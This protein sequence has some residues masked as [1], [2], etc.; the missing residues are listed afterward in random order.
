[1][2]VIVPTEAVVASIVLTLDGVDVAVAVVAIV[3]VAVLI[4]VPVALALA[5]VDTEPSISIANWISPLTL[6]L[7]EILAEPCN[8]ARLDRL[9][10]LPKASRLSMF[11]QLS[12]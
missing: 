2:A 4:F 10:I 9:S 12:N 8:T 6:A 7:V 1:V 3:A 11:P 5:L